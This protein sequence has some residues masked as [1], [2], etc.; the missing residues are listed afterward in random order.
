MRGEVRRVAGIPLRVTPDVVPVFFSVPAD[1][2][3]ACRAAHRI[4]WEA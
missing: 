3:H 1:Y 4:D 2:L